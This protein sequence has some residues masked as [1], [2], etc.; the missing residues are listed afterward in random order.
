LEVL[1]EIVEVLLVEKANAGRLRHPA[2]R[3]CHDRLNIGYG[4]LIY[5]ENAG[6]QHLMDL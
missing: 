6:F 3:P 4:A 5:I 1:S 2:Y